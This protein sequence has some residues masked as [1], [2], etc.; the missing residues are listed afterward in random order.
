MCYR[1]VLLMLLLLLAP[2]SLLAQ[3]QSNLG[4]EVTSVKSRMSDPLQP[5]T[6]DDTL[7]LDEFLDV[8]FT[9]SVD[10]T[11]GFWVS[12]CTNV[13]NQRCVIESYRFLPEG[14]FVGKIKHYVPDDLTPLI[15]VDTS[16][17]SALVIIGDLDR[18]S[19]G[20]MRPAQHSVITVV[21]LNE[22]FSINY[23]RA[24]SR[25]IWIIPLQ[26]SFVSIQGSFYRII[27][28]TPRLL[29]E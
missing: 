5:Y 27:G 29:Q 8:V 2:Y 15:S 18:S 28:H 7:Q 19:K 3:K 11:I 24:N 14:R 12:G 16:F 13:D 22:E 23:D 6:D 20:W 4:Q 1:F 9:K 25:S 10:T 21:A 26:P 17:D